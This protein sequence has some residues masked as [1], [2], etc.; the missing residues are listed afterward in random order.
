MHNKINKQHHKQ[1]LG[2]NMRHGIY[3]N[4]RHESNSLHLIT[5]LNRI[6]IGQK[7]DSGAQWYALKNYFGQG[8]H[9]GKARFENMVVCTGGICHEVKQEHINK[10]F[11]LINVKVNFNRFNHAFMEL[12]DAL[13]GLGE[14]L[15][16]GEQQDIIDAIEDKIVELEDSI[17]S[18]IPVGEDV[19]EYLDNI[20]ANRIT[21]G[22]S[23]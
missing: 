22:E 1:I 11:E 21:N 12:T 17:D 3:V 7:L 16:S 18:D 14:Y 10:V 6:I 4:G 20:A 9:L 5:G 2:V 19:S 8:N 23:L 13:H 15:T